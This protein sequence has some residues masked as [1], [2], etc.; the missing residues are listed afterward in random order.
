ML[1]YTILI[2]KIISFLIPYVEPNPTPHC[3]YRFTL[4][5]FDLCWLLYEQNCGVNLYKSIMIT[6]LVNRF[7]KL[8]R[9]CFI[10]PE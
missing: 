3:K 4:C 8:N 10:K 1:Y 2:S 6:K 5:R 9:N 7:I